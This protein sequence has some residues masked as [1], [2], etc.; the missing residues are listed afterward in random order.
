MERRK[1]A[2]SQEYVSAINLREPSDEVVKVESKVK[3]EILDKLLKKIIRPQWTLLGIQINENEEVGVTKKSFR[4]AQQVCVYSVLNLCALFWTIGLFHN[5]FQLMTP[6][7]AYT[8]ILLIWIHSVN[9]HTILVPF[10][11]KKLDDIRAYLL[12]YSVVP[13]NV[14]KM[15]SRRWNYFSV[16]IIVIIIFNTTVTGGLQ[17]RIPEID[18][19]P[20]ASLPLFA[21]DLPWLRLIIIVVNQTAYVVWHIIWLFDLLAFYTFCSLVQEEFYEYNFRL[22]TDSNWSEIDDNRIRY[23]NLCSLALQVDGYLNLRTGIDFFGAIPMVM[24][25]IYKLMYPLGGTVVT[26]TFI[27]WLSILVCFV[28]V[29][30]KKGRDVSKAGR[31]PLET[32]L[33]W[34]LSTDLTNQ[35]DFTIFLLQ[36]QESS[37]KIT[38]AGITEIT[39]KSLLSLISYMVTLFFIVI[40]WERG[41]LKELSDAAKRANETV[42]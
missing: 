10:D 31:M 9:I 22:K 19:F 32:L 6:G 1:S 17:F 27:T 33:K 23:D 3:N 26:V 41:R 14:I 11:C 15:Y 36:I 38:A 37:P 42:S 24:F 2:R 12:A 25:I 13:E 39:M 20:E 35:N 40:E 16:L 8:I 4:V 18:D 29:I 28:F 7:T 5:N 30:C 34:N 21:L